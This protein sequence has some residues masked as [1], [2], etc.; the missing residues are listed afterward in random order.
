[1]G[2]TAA[3]AEAADCPS[4]TAAGAVEAVHRKAS[5]APEEA[6]RRL[7]S[8]AAQLSR[9]LVTLIGELRAL[10]LQADNELDEAN[11]GI[12]IGD[13][14]L[15]NRGARLRVVGHG[16]RRADAIEDIAD[17]LGFLGRH[18]ETS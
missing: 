5:N 12:G 2:R 17:N 4:S 9:Q 10:R 8:R 6:T 13:H 15:R 3:A 11:A 16:P 1:M 18:D 14:F 7:L